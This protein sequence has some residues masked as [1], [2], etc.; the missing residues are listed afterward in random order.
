VRPPFQFPKYVS[1]LGSPK[2]DVQDAT[3][4]IGGYVSSIEFK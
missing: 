4:S 1:I 2:A 3:L